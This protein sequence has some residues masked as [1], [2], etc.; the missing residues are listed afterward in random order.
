MKANYPQ[1]FFPTPTT[2]RDVRGF[3]SSL[4]LFRALSG[5]IQHH[6]GQEGAAFVTVRKLIPIS[7]DHQDGAN[8]IFLVIPKVFWNGSILGY[9]LDDLLTLILLLLQK[10]A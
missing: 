9:E 2:Y 10:G 8:T 1:T 6:R 4:S 5:S 3:L 7:A